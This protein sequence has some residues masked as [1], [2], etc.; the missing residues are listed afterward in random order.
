MR[1]KSHDILISKYILHLIVGEDIPA[2]I[3]TQFHTVKLYIR[4][5]DNK[6]NLY[7]DISLPYL[8]NHSE[9]LDIKGDPRYFF[10]EGHDTQTKICKYRC[11]IKPFGEMKGVYRILNGKRV[12]IM[13]IEPL[14]EL[15]N[16]L[17]IKD[18]ETLNEKIINFTEKYEHLINTDIPKKSLP[19]LG[20]GYV[21]QVPDL[22]EH[23]D[24]TTENGLVENYCIDEAEFKQL[25]LIKN[26][27]N[28]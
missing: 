6:L 9:F 11:E 7:A 22:V 10:E 15:D 12:K 28:N 25:R 23:A 20:T 17:C 21:P 24:K 2:N 3:P 18:N 13:T 4:D 19:N 26:N 5:K 14:C 16:K 27:K 8:I 1:K